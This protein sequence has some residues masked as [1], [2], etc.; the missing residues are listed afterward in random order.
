MKLQAAL[1]TLSLEECEKLLSETRGSIDIAEV[2]TPFVIEEGMRPVRVFKEK[3]PGIEVLADVKIMDAGEY[4]ADKCFEADIARDAARVPRSA[5]RLAF[6]SNHDENS[7][8]GTEIERLGAAWQV[9]EV[10]NFT[11]PQTQPLIYT[12]QE[13]GLSRRLEFFEKDAI[14][15]WSANEYTEFY[16]YLIDLKH[17]NPAL[18]AG[19][20]GGKMKYLKGMPAGVLGFIRAVPGNKVTVL[21]NLTANPVVVKGQKLEPWGWLVEAE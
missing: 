21:A 14:T 3:F 18:D 12:G 1:D 4:E 6:T 16:K 7:W 8:A 19:E 5:F 2:G 10:L 11:L 13:I 15:D 17:A 20:R 9:M